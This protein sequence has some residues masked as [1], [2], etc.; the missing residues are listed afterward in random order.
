MYKYTDEESVE[1]ENNLVN[2]IKKDD[3]ISSSNI[4]NKAIDL[5]GEITVRREK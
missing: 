5:F 1:K 2:L 3:I 4:T